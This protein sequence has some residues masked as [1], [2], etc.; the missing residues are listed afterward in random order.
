MSDTAKSCRTC[1]WFVDS[2]RKNYR[3]EEEGKCGFPDDRMPDA[4]IIIDRHATGNF[5]DECGC[6][7]AKTN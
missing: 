1:R 4:M 3:N 7:E 2:G 5:G 6:Y